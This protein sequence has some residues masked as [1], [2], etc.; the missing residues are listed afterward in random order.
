MARAMALDAPAV[1]NPARSALSRRGAG[2]LGASVWLI[3]SG[4]TVAGQDLGVFVGPYRVAMERGQVGTLKGTAFIE[5]RKLGEAAGPLAGVRVVL[6]PSRARL[7]ADLEAIKVHARDS[8]SRYLAAAG[9]VGKLKET[10]EL[11]LVQA[12]AAELIFRA[13]TDEEGRFELAGVPAGEWVLLGWGEVLHAKAPRKIPQ[14]DARGAFLLEPLPSGYRAVTYWLVK[15]TVAAGQEV[16][17]ELHDRNVWLTG[18]A[19]EKTQGVIQKK[20]P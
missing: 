5:P 7:V 1:E 16:T 14:R 10:Y 2:I 13:V 18:V 17:V 8:A 6:L 4:G 20:A 9:E 3:A 11:A 15:R 12:G 19:E